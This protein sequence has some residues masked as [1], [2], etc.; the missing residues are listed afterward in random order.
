MQR[1]YIIT[2]IIFAI[3]FLAIW[4]V[5]L[6]PVPIQTATGTIRGKA[7]REGGVYWQG[8]Q[9][10]SRGFR[11]PT[12]IEIAEA[13]VFQIEV[14]GLPEPLTYA[15]NTVASDSFAVGD[16]VHVEFQ[17]VGVPPFWTRSYV[18]EIQPAR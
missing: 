7:F 17:T 2:A 1:F 11:T 4:F 13:Y 9:G 14:G 12:P 5:F 15:L 8:H 16:V 18:R 3:G 10:L 6:R